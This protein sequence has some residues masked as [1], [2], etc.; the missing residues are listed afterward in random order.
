MKNS[1]RPACASFLLL[2][3]SLSG[4]GCGANL[5]ELES[6]YE[7]I[8]ELEGEVS[9]LEDKCAETQAELDKWKVSE[10]EAIRS[11]FE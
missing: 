8:K 2:L 6:A 1:I 9:E 7:T 11:L 5:E 3:L 10:E 4:T